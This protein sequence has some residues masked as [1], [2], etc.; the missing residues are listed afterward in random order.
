[1]KWLYFARVSDELLRYNRIRMFM[2]DNK[3]YLNLSRIEYSIREDEVILLHSVINGDYFDNLEPFETNPFVKH[4]EYT[5]ADPATTTSEI[6][7]KNNDS[8]R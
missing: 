7:K 3:Q 4:V 5:N 2:L 6:K 1:M 8:S